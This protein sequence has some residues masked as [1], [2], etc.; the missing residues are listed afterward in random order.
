MNSASIKYY[1]ELIRNTVGDLVS[2]LKEHA[3]DT[4]DIANWMT[5]FG[6]V[7]MIPAVFGL[8]PQLITRP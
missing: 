1:E 6:Y 3:D 4:V 8:D 5:F 2:G 7:T